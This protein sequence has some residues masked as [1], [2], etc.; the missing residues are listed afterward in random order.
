MHVT[1]VMAGLAL[2]ARRLQFVGARFAMAGVTLI[3]RI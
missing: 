2:N 1:G 3:A